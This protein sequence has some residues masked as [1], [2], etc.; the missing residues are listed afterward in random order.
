MKGPQG[1]TVHSQPYIGATAHLIGLIAESFKLEFR[2]KSYFRDKSQ[3][4]STS[5]RVYS[6][7]RP[8]IPAVLKQ[9]EFKVAKQ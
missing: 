1:A 7:K 6:T 3:S 4:A 2:T 8:E 9:T 5:G